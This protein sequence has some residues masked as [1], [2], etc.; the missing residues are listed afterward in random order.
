M[1]LP[2]G[3]VAYFDQ[4]SGISYRCHS[5]FAVVG[6][7]GQPAHCREEAKKYEVIETLGGKGWNYQ[8]GEPISS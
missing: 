8:T 7:I 5:C 3:G 4:D 6:S 1:H 2:C